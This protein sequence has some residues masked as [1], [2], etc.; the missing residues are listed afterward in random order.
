MKCELPD[1]W[2]PMAEALTLGD[3]HRA[4]AEV[5]SISHVQAVVEDTIAKEIR[6]ECE[7]LCSKESTSLFKM[8]SADDLLRFSAND[9]DDELKSK[10]PKFRS[11]LMAAACNTRQL[12]KNKLKTPETITHGTMA[13]AGVLLNCRS[14]LMNSHQMMTALQLHQGGATQKTF[15][16]LQKRFLCV[17]HQLMYNVQDQFAEGFDDEVR[18]WQTRIVQDKIKEEELKT[19]LNTA[20]HDEAKRR[21]DELNETRQDSYTPIGDNVDIRV[22]II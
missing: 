2:L 7:Q 22:C 20:D 3:K 15:D 17:N 21:L 6:R 1:E 13:A 14:Q 10:A 5:A 16:R 9:Q 19:L 4:Y 12:P 8:S 18:E 11:F